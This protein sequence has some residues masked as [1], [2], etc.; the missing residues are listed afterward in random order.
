MTYQEWA[1]EYRESAAIL[2]ER[3]AALRE[4]QKTA[5][6][7]ELKELDFRIQT[8]YMMYLDC[9]RTANILGKR[10]GGSF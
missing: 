6:P 1:E 9:M 5:A 7:S 4:Q 8:M 3:V 2:R 10:K